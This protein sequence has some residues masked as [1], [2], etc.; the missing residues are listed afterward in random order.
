MSLTSLLGG[1]RIFATN[2]CSPQN[3]MAV[4]IDKTRQY[5]P[6]NALC[7][8]ILQSRPMDGP[9]TKTIMIG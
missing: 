2:A 3:D 4:A 9:Q 1:T 8:D 7:H 5:R 6:Q